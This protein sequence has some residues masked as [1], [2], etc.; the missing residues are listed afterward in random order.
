MSDFRLIRFAVLIACGYSAAIAAAP[1]ALT[2]QE[3]AASLLSP[4]QV[5]AQASVEGRGPLDPD[6]WIETRNFLPKQDNDRW[7][8]ARID[9]ATGAVEYQIY[10]IIEAKGQA[11]RPQRLTFMRADGLGE[12]KLDRLSFEPK[13]YSSY[14]CWI[15]EHAVASLSRADME[16]AAQGEGEWVAKLFGESQSGE[17]YTF[18]SEILGLLLAVDRE[19]AGL[20]K[21]E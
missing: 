18:K 13:C 3:R 10:F 17:I 21:S 19:L 14:N 20:T 4:A 11:F 5:A 6:M 7:F 16:F 12:T 2:K 1:P 15:K 8:R 9:K